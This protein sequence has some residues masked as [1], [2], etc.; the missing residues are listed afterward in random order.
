MSDQVILY[1][2]VGCHLCDAFIDELR[3]YDAKLLAR[4][5][6]VDVDD[7]EADVERYGDKVPILLQGET[8]ICRYFFDAE[9]IKSCLKRQG[10]SLE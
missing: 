5:T 4:L 2:R 8:E 9:K 3:Q 1:T 6:M 10:D 7:N